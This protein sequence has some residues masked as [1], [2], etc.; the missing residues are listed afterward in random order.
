MKERGGNLNMCIKGYISEKNP[1]VKLMENPYAFEILNRDADFD[2]ELIESNIESKYLLFK[3]K[4]DSFIGYVLIFCINKI[5]G[6]KLRELYEI[7][8]KYC[9]KYSHYN[10]RE[11]DF[12][13]ITNNIAKETLEAVKEY[14]EKY[15]HRRPITIIVNKLEMIEEE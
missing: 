5:T 11:F 6:E 4:F 14:N 13:I 2:V 9:G 15:A 12:I 8:K 3:R 7:Y 1:L 10:F